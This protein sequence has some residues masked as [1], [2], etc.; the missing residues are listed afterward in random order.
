MNNLTVWHGI[1]VLSV[2]LSTAIM[3]VGYFIKKWMKRVEVQLEKLEENYKTIETEQNQQKLNYIDRFQSVELKIERT[4]KNIINVI[5]D[6]KD[7]ITETFVSKSFCQ[8]IQE[9]KPKGNF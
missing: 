7:H 6:L 4:E 8:F 2:I 1:S 5:N 3:I 9:H